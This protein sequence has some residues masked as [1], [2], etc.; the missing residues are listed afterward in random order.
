MSAAQF[1]WLAT[2]RPKQGRDPRHTYCRIEGLRRETFD[3]ELVGRVR[4]AKLQ[5]DERIKG[6]QDAKCC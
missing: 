5:F 1:P 4:R 3:D 6:G 2:K